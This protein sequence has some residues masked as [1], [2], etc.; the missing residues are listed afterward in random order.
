MHLGLMDVSCPGAEASLRPPAAAVCS[1]EPTTHR[2]HMAGQAGTM[3]SPARM[4]RT[5]RPWHLEANRIAI[6]KARLVKINIQTIMVCPKH[7]QHTQ[8]QAVAPIKDMQALPRLRGQRLITSTLMSI[9]VV[10]KPLGK[11]PLQTTTSAAPR[12]TQASPP[13]LLSPRVSTLQLPAASSASPP[14]SAACTMTV[15]STSPQPAT[16]SLPMRAPGHQKN[17]RRCLVPAFMMS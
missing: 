13:H 11:R 8:Q 14:P 6:T 15:P 2:G 16:E 5:I 3:L 9:L 4:Y 1:E 7:P 12:V 17:T 10:P